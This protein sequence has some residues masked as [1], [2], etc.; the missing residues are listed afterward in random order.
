MREI[1]NSL[2]YF[3]DE[4]Q[5]AIETAKSDIQY[6]TIESLKVNQI[7]C[8]GFLRGLLYVENLFTSYF[9]N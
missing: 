9:E 2:H 1:K 6:H 5:S 7:E 4:L 8:E 3:K